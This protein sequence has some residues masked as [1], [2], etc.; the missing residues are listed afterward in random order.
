MNVTIENEYF[1]AVLSTEG[2]E[3]QSL[4]RKSD[5]KDFIWCG[6]PAIW[7]NHAPILFPFIGRPVAG[8]FM[9]ED[10]K[11]EY[12]KN[13]GFV[14]GSETKIICQEKNKLIFE[15]TD[16][17]N[18]LYRFPYHFSLQS[19]YELKGQSLLWKLTVKNT[20]TKA[21]KF[22]LGTHTAFAC[23]RKDDSA[24]TK[25]SDYVIEF[26]D[27][28]KL[29]GVKCTPEGYVAADEKASVPVTFEYGEKESGFVPLTENGF[30]NGHLFTKFTSK[31]IG[32]RNKKDNSLVKISSEGFPY[33]MLW[34]NTCGQPS[35]VCIEPWM[36]L[37]ESDKSDHNWEHLPEMNLLQPG[38]S[39]NSIQ[40][41]SVE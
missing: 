9:I 21:F 11:C 31:W 25:I 17:E 10:K 18:T 29:T 4:K 19:E 5:G 7:K 13:H 26:A 6:D 32:L 34:Q 33:C 27:H 16:G 30:G 23:P 2:A 40:N 3:L 8:Y 37:P 24:D 36:G 1:T 12:S 20:D 38:E 41:I 14:R 22:A 35:F 39:F 28:E 15:L